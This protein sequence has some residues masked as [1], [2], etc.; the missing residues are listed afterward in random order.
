VSRRSATP[1]PLAVAGRESLRIGGA[2]MRVS[3]N[4]LD[5][6]PPRGWHAVRKDNDG[7]RN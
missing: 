7:N 4:L 1:A 3:S 2:R 5:F 6:R